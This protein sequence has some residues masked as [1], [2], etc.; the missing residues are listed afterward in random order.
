MSLNTIMSIANAGMQVA[1]TG[2][3][4][5][6][7]NIS[8]VNTPGYVR[9]V[10]NQ[11]S[12]ALNGAGAGV[13]VAQVQRVAD[14]YLQAASLSAS[15]TS[16]AASAV[17]DLLDQAQ[18]VFGDPSS[19]TSYFNQLNSV[20]S[21]FTAAAN[22]PS[23]SLS[24]SQVIDQLNT[25]LS[26]TQRISGQLQGFTQQAD[27]KIGSDVDQVNQL[28]GQ[29][30][31][32]N[33]DI[34]RSLA[35]GSDATGS[36][37]AQS[38]L[39]DKL[40]TFVDVKITPKSGGGVV[41]RTSAGDLLAGDGGPA[42]L[43]YNAAGNGAGVLSLTPHGS[44]QSTGVTIGDGELRGLLDV[45][46]NQL[47]AIQDQLGEF[48]SKT[49]DAINQ[50]SNAATAVPPPSTLTGR[51]TGLDLPTIIGDFSG[52]TTLAVV[53]ASG[54]QQERVDVDFTAGTM[55]VNGGAATSF[56]PATFLS[57]LN[58]ALSG[59]ATASF[60]TGALT[61]STTSASNGIAIQDDPTTPSNDAGRGFSQF[62]GLNDLVTTTGITNYA[63]GLKA[64]D[65]AGFTAGGT[66]TFRMS[67]TPGSV[68]R[69]ITVTMPAGGAM[70]NLLSTL[71]A[72]VGGVGQYGQFVLDSQGTM[73]FQPNTGS[74]T[75]LTVLSD[76]TQRGAGGPSLSQLFGIGS[77]QRA[78]RAGTF[79]LNSAVTANPMA[80]PLA[81][82]NLANAALGQPVLA[83][84]DNSGALALAKAAN[85][86]LNFGAAG[87]L[88]ATTSNV[89]QYA[90]LLAGSIGRKASAADD[91]KTAAD[92][93]KTEA[94]TRRSSVE[95]V[96][97]DEELVNLTTY[98][99]AYSASARLVQAVK[100]M[101]DTL[102]QMT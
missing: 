18:T 56:T 4:T 69:D 86:S 22:D 30:D 31:S 36:M 6:S 24:R 87:D 32:L 27:S 85:T 96:N 70:A 75:T 94:D 43:S 29:I 93:V 95:G 76:K 49:A 11:S 5:T 61:L 51:N 102:L 13:T 21:A 10:V 59:Y 79:S 12:T 48:V 52:K 15:A 14:S 3:T 97:L 77:A 16:S 66:I 41:L 62:F 60:N 73:T 72:Q 81:T 50:A 42:T 64:T 34:S 9:K 99:Q 63:T 84:G 20:F 82:L 92:A 57:S 98:Q 39:I 33:S 26:S 55:S 40:S 46:Q 90:S 83:L 37:D 100:D 1:Q 2:L 58:T 101:Y 89:T 7:D 47:P 45:R 71:N 28:L 38:Q 25:F 23:S 68:T 88:S 74:S 67:D 8:N 80:M 53:D 91:A 44:T 17:S 19:S 35:S 65:T 54:N 78:S